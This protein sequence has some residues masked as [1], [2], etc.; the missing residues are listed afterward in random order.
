MLKPSSLLF[1]TAL[2]AFAAPVAAAQDPFE[3]QVYEYE[4]VPVG[5]WNLETHI[6][7]VAKGE[8]K[9]QNHLT[10]ELTRGITKNFE[11]AG[12]LVT[13]SRPGVNGELAGWRLRPR[14]KVPEDKLPFKFSISTEFGFPKH[15]YEDVDWTLE[16]RPILEWGWGKTQLDINPVFG[17]P[18]GR[19]ASGLAAMDFDF[20]PGVR[21]GYT[22]NPK[23]DLSMEYYGNTGLITD[24]SAT[25]NQVH[26]FF[27]GADIQLA[28]NIV[29]NVGVGFGATDAGNTLVYKMRLGV[30]W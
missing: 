3:I 5:K 13:S 12:Y 18:F 29:W 27:P 26:Q 23:V 4:L 22:V 16:I 11:M 1:A 28:S 20:E 10:F 7:R 6:N 24:P 8:M 2:I 21:L 25:E 17:R 19:S 14:W 15:E 9:D 30:M